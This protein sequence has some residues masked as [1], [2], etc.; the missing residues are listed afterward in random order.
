MTRKLIILSLFLLVAQASSAQDPYPPEGFVY[1]EEAVPSIVIEPRYYSEENFVG[2][3]IE[4]YEAAKVII[5]REA[6]KALKDVQLGLREKNLGLK[7]FDAYRPQQSVDHFVKW[8]RDLD[9]TLQKNQYY[10]DVPKDQLF[11]RGYIAA[12]SSHSRGSTVDV[13]LID[14]Q[15][16]K[17]LDMGTPFDFFSPK[18]WPSSDE[19]SSKQKQNRMMLQRVMKKHGFEPLE[20]EWWHF[21][22]RGEPYPES[23]FD[24]KVK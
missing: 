19:V 23:Y 24:F 15:T 6:A 18:S 13:T 5:S 12:N 3:P 1:L 21:T 9:D 2:Q 20:T 14:L 8:A 22:L 11:E 7:V 17:E 10:P 4:G 16:G